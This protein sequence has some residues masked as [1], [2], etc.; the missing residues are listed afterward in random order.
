MYLH[1][2]LNENENY[3]V[4]LI[5]PSSVS[6]T[7]L[8]GNLWCLLS[9]ILFHLYRLSSRSWKLAVTQFSDL[10]LSLISTTI[11]C[12]HLIVVDVVSKVYWFLF[13]YSFCLLVESHPKHSA[14]RTDFHYPLRQQYYSRSHSD[15]IVTP[16]SPTYI[17]CNFWSLILQTLIHIIGLYSWALLNG[18]VTKQWAINAVHEW[19][20][21]WHEP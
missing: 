14:L 4:T 1:R 6:L 19:L 13:F 10:F 15:V 7:L 11:N 3:F 16:V 18:H 17:S 8:K 5:S 9:Y 2:A 21:K 12:S 20:K